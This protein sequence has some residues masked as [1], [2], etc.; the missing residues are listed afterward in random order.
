MPFVVSRRRRATP[1]WRTSDA[2]GFQLAVIYHGWVRFN[3]TE[4]WYS[5]ESVS[6]LLRQALGEL[7]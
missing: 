4:P 5:W 2:V 1:A 7:A 3:G 6:G